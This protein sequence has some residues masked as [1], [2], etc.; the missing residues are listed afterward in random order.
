MGYW[1]IVEDLID[2]SDILIFVL[3]ARMPELSRNKELERKAIIKKKEVVC[4]YNK[5]DLV[6][7]ENIKLL[8]EKYPDSFFVSGTKNIGIR[9]LR[10][11]LQILGKKMKLESPRIGV[12]GYPNLGKSAI[13]NALARGSRALVADMPGTTRGVQWVRVGSLRILDSPGVIP[14]EDKSSKLTLLGSKHPEKILD[15]TKVA[16][17]IIG[18]FVGKDKSV[19]EKAYKIEI[20]PL[21]EYYDILLEIGRKRGYLKKGGEVEETKTAITIVKDWQ[22]GKLIL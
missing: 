6:K 11:H 18:M 22:K 4:A 17:E 1:P 10:R 3:D 13:I 8:K 14:Y 7:E 2:N 5:I 15:P 9:E 21:T 16:L 20:K 19:L 12:V